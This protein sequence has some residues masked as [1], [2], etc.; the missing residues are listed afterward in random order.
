MMPSAP[1]RD[2]VCRSPDEHAGLLARFGGIAV[3][4]PS[5]IRRTAMRVEVQGKPAAIQSLATIRR[6]LQAV[7]QV[8]QRVDRVVT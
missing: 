5:L 2:A 8:T 3:A 6:C 1:G 7:S 4:A